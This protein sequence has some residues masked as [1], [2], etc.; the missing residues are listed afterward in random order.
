M[1]IVAKQL[2]R[3]CKFVHYIYY[4]SFYKCIIMG[5]TSRGRNREGNRKN[6]R[7]CCSNSAKK[8]HVQPKQN[9]ENMQLIG[10]NWRTSLWDTLCEC[11]AK[12]MCQTECV[13]E[14]PFI[15]AS[16]RHT[17]AIIML[18]NENLDIPHL[19]GGWIISAKKKCLLT[20][21]MN[22][23]WEKTWNM[24]VTLIWNFNINVSYYL[25]NW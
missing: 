16:P 8:W 4:Y 9:N 13:L 17:C 20:Q 7:S 19:W 3:K 11:L 12:E 18:S 21:I 24:L 22:N 10:C 23:I 6:E 5:L 14:W 2:Y 15:V 25:L 1:Q